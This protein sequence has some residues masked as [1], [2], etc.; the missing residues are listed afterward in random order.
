M[1][2]M[3]KD[4]RRTLTQSIDDQAAQGRR[5]LAFAHKVGI[6]SSSSSPAALTMCLQTCSASAA[7]AGA[8][9]S[10]AGLSC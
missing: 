8:G 3:T 4:A 7:L 1:T 5:I 10:P 9:C 6:C 2:E